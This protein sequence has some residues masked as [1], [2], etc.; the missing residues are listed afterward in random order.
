MPYVASG[1][2]CRPAGKI[3]GINQP[4]VLDATYLSTLK[5]A[6]KRHQRRVIPPVPL[7]VACIS[8]LALGQS[9]G[10]R[11]QI[12]FSVDVG[13]VERNM[14]EPGAN[15]VDVNAGATGRYDA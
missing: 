6:Q 10:F 11:L 9:L 4:V 1:N 2:M 5:R 3:F 15:R 7:R 13:R 8:N 12:Y 14:P